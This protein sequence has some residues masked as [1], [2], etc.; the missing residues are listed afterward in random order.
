M[1]RRT[2]KLSFWVLRPTDKDERLN[3]ELP[4]IN[5]RVTPLEG[6]EGHQI[7]SL[8]DFPE[9]KGKELPWDP[10]LRKYGRLMDSLGGVIRGDSTPLLIWNVLIFLLIYFN[11]VEIP[12]ALMVDDSYEKSSQI[13]RLAISYSIALDLLVI[14]MVAVRPRI[15]YE[16]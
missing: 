4:L 5:P 2:S 13:S 7:R 16:D 9:K 11:L 10:L 15:S 8:L 3:I 6:P 1:M 12:I 14:D